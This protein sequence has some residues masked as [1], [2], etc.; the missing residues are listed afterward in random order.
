VCSHFCSS[1]RKKILIS[2]TRTNRQRLRSLF[3]V[4]L[5]LILATT[6]LL[7]APP[8]VAE[9]DRAVEAAAVYQPGQ[10]FEPFR[11]LEDWVRQSVAEPAQ[12][13]SIE[14]A[15]I[16][17]LNPTASFEAQRFAC[18]QLGVIGSQTA[19]PVLARLLKDNKTSGLACLALSTYPKGAA[20]DILR[21]ALASANGNTRRQIVE[22]LGDRRDPKSVKTLA[23]LARSPESLTSDA[24]ISSLGKI[25]TR[26]AWKALAALGKTSTI[27][28]SAPLTEA[29]LTCADRLAS[30]GDRKLARAI[31]SDLL[32]PSHPAYVRRGAFSALLRLDNDGGEQRILQTLHGSDPVLKPVA[33]AAIR[34]VPSKT[35]SRRFA[36][37]LSQLSPLEQVWMIDS[38]AARADEP[39][40]E[41]VGA[42]VSASDGQVRRAAIAALGRIGGA[43]AV[44]L[45]ARAAAETH[46]PDQLKAIESALVELGGDGETDRAIISQLQVSR[47]NGLSPL[48]N[49]LAQREGAIANPIIVQETANADPTVAKAAFRALAK[50]AGA[51]DAA[52]LLSK[53]NGPLEPTVRAEAEAATAAALGKIDDTSRRSTLVRDAF[54]Q[55][56]TD[57]R[58]ISF[59]NLL[60]GCADADTLALVTT[61]IGNSNAKLRSAAFSV[62]ADWPDIAAWDPLARIYRDPENEPARAVALRSLVRLAGEANERADAALLGRYMQ[63]LAGARGDMDLKLILGGLAGVPRPE[64][65]QLV[66]PL[67]SNSGVR[68]EAEVAVRKIAESIKAQNPEAA[69]AALQRLDSRQ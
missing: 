65:L 45:L 24:A 35:A 32:E 64:A 40:R 15:L 43:S 34:D 59:L 14:T 19:L 46:E 2:S 9:I 55:A 28:S 29:M 33:I 50:T 26:D 39:A 1:R 30:A 18:K 12:R 63:L 57:D 62:L 20:D 22:T 13:N 6:P 23:A 10:G 7:A 54:T 27:S 36:E 5:T 41:A 16:K 21:S 38:L 25:G 42:S 44:P 60:P 61:A 31:L 66:L 56:N 3:E 53:L 58:R 4:F 17:L 51:S 67:L 11:R 68:V 52:I 49:A 69:N 37:G 8:T 48:I 47:P